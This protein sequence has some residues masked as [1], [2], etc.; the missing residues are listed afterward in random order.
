MTSTER[1]SRVR[2][3]ENTAPQ[4]QKM[5]D[6]IRRASDRMSRLIDDLLD[7]ERIEQHRLPLERRGHEASSLVH[8]LFESLEP[9]ASEKSITMHADTDRARV[10]EV[11]CDR[12]RIHQVFE[13]LVGNAIKFAPPGGSLWIRAEATADHV[14]FAIADDGPGIAPERL[15]HV[16]DRY[17]QAKETAHLGTGL[18]LAIAKGIV[19][20]HGG[21]IWVESE[22]GKGSTFFFTLPVVRRLGDQPSPPQLT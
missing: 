14:V 21:R 15:A 20:A 7:I 19:E 5:V 13:N 9:L 1:L 22:V 2:L 16:F 12:D 10:V 18:G 11:L 6:A 8:H 4:T 17:W 3:P